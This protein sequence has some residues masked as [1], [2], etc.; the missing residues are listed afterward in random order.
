MGYTSVYQ[1]NQ[2]TKRNDL[3]NSQVMEYLKSIVP[4]MFQVR[5]C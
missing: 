5:V 3:T 2:Q 1:C 4:K